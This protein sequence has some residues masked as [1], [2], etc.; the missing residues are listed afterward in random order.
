[1][2]GLELGRKYRE[3]KNY[4]RYEVYRSYYFKGASSIKIDLRYY[5]CFDQRKA[6]VTLVYMTSSKKNSTCFDKSLYDISCAS[7]LNEWPLRV[8]LHE[9]LKILWVL[10]LSRN[11]L[12]VSVCY[13]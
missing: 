2:E 6:T 3:D 8:Q 7:G 11:G 4:S 1:M 9:L 12:R 5:F 10:G 13:V